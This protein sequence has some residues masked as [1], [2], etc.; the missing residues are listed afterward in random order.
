MTRR[1]P[2]AATFALLALL[3]VAP[4]ASAQTAAH[5]AVGAGEVRGLEL[6]LEGALHATRGEPL[7]WL[8][9]VHEVVG[10]SDLRPAAGARVRAV[11]SFAPAEATE[12]TADAFGRVTLE[13]PVPPDAPERFGVVLEVF[14]AASRVQRRF[15]LSVTTVDPRV[16][17]L[18]IARTFVEASGRTAAGAPEAGDASRGAIRAL[19]RLAHRTTLRPLAGVPVLLALRDDAGRPQGAP[20]R[21][22]TDPAGLATHTFRA[23]RDAR[24][25]LHV[26]ARLDERIAD[27]PARGRSAPP[28]AQASVR[29]EAPVSQTLLVAVAPERVL[30]APGAPIDVD[31]VVRTADGR[32]VAGATLEVDGVSR[33]RGEARPTTDAR[34]RAGSAGPRRS[35]CPGSRRARGAPTASLP[36]SW[37]SR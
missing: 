23:P 1:I 34:G 28:S 4:R 9:A 15:E 20:A 24:G 5:R 3:L 30:T 21:V 2:F 33:R 31:V 18:R 11:T 16:L 22:V 35:R 19:V 10:L 17:S 12:R 32:P 6:G 36:R 29:V 14:A 7:R 37:T 25:T 27:A 8:L 26:D 13:V